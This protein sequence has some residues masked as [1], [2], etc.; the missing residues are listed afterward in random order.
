MS[1]TT[2]ELKEL[3]IDL[4]FQTKEITID[5]IILPMRYINRL[6]ESKMENAWAVNISMACKPSSTQDVT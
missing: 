3:G 5:E 1:N 4:D 2:K 6:T